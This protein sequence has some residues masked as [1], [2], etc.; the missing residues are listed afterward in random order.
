[1]VCLKKATK[2]FRRRHLIKLCSG[3]DLH[4]NNTY[5]GIED[6]KGKRLM[7]RKIDNDPD[8]ILQL[9]NPYREDISA[10]VV[11]SMYNWY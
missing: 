3:F 6:E 11:E 10:V 5:I 8:Q 9:L 2:L 4:A 1:M 7:T